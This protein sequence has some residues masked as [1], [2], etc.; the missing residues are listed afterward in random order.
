MKRKRWTILLPITIFYISFS[1]YSEIDNRQ[2]ETLIL[3]RNEIFARK[4]YKFQNGILSS[5]FRRFEWYT[6]KEKDVSLSREDKT[7]AEELLKSEK[8]LL[9]RYADFLTGEILWNETEGEY[10]GSAEKT[11]IPREH[12]RNPSAL[13]KTVPYPSED[14][15]IASIRPSGTGNDPK[16]FDSIRAA[17]NGE[18]DSVRYFIRTYSRDGRYIRLWQC[19]ADSIQQE[20]CDTKFVLEKDTLLA[21]SHSVAQTSYIQ[22]W[23]YVYLDGK[24]FSGKF[25]MKSAGKIE[26]NLDYHYE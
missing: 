21:V 13:T 22:E 4:G 12:R 24:L 2:L 17:K 1:L 11:E 18:A 25:R 6:P 23:I 3:K 19:Y 9:S 7:R 14:F 8:E 15:F 16:L 10:F 20:L 5:H 26:R